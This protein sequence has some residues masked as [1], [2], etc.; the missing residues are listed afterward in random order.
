MKS[1]VE[2]V[3]RLQQAIKL[4]ETAPDNEASV[5]FARQALK[6]TEQF[7]DFTLVKERRKRIQEFLDSL[8]ALEPYD[9][10]DAGDDIGDE[11][12]FDVWKWRESLDGVNLYE[13]ALVENDS[14][15]DLLEQGNDYIYLMGSGAVNMQINED[16]YDAFWFS[17]KI[18]SDMLTYYDG[19]VLA[20]RDL[21]LV[22][23]VVNGVEGVL[24]A[25]PYG[26]EDR[27]NLVFLYE[28]ALVLLRRYHVVGLQMELHSDARM[29]LSRKGKYNDEWMLDSAL[30]QAHDVNIKD[31]VRC[32]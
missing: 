10:E 32:I 27:E 29:Q 9:E 30:W 4:L 21:N 1:M 5:I 18:L 16:V 6:D 2:I 24:A 25:L 11:T 22:L 20:E 23:S 26:G 12:I 15:E 14:Y 17:G 7:A 8:V 31:V 13:R 3:G 19:N 28:E